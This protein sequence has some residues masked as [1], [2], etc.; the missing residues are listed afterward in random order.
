MEQA[1]V[2]KEI[3]NFDALFII[4][5]QPKEPIDSPKQGLAGSQP[6]ITVVLKPIECEC[7]E[8]SCCSR[9]ASSLTF[10]DPIIIFSLRTRNAAPKSLLLVPIT[11]GKSGGQ[12]KNKG[13][14]CVALSLAIRDG[15]RASEQGVKSEKNL[16][17]ETIASRRNRR[18]T[19]Y[20]SY[21]VISRPAAFS[22][23]SLSLFLL[24]V[25]SSACFSTSPSSFH[26][27]EQNVPTGRGA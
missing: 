10:P 8:S 11:R 1:F 19:D 4:I 27:P 22:F 3:T 6:Q 7:N 5:R 12:N 13:E 2:L 26:F 15:E 25:V 14:N 24:P 17:A 16:T 23:S 20:S 21:A 18:V 9:R